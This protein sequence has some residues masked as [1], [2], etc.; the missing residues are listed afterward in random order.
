MS[1][2]S[3]SESELDTTARG[4]SAKGFLDD[5]SS[6]ISPAL[7]GLVGVVPLTSG[8]R[9][10]TWTGQSLHHIQLVLSQDRDLPKYP[11][12]YMHK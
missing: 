10:I 4:M 3:P 6:P 2:S 11:L 5:T 9:L 1:E 8:G 7:L 12:M